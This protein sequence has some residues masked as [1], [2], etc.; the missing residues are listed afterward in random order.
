MKLTVA[1]RSIGSGPG[2]TQLAGDLSVSGSVDHRGEGEEPALWH[3]S[4]PLD[5]P[6]L[7]V[8]AYILKTGT[9]TEQK[10]KE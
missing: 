7:Y 5:S 2:A 10:Q 9:R 1:R 8:L 6:V 3:S 4:F